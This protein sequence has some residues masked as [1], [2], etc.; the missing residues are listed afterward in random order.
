MMRKIKNKYLLFFLFFFLF[1]FSKNVFA[2]DEEQ[3]PSENTLYKDYQYVIDSYDVNVVVN[4][5]NTFDITETITV[6]YQVPKHGIYRKIP[7]RN[8]ITRLDG[9]TSKNYAVLTNPAVNE[10]FSFTKE[11]GEY[12]FKIGKNDTTLTGEKTYVIQYQYNIGKDPLKEKDEFYFN[13]IGDSW[14]T[15]IGNVTFLI[16]MP[17]TFDSSKVGFSKGKKGSSDSR[18]IDYTVNQN[19]IIGKY[20]GVLFPEEALTVRLELEEGYFVGAGLPTFPQDYIL[21]LF[22]IF[23]LLVSIFLHHHFGRDQELIETVEFYPPEGL[24]SLEI[25]F[26]Y[27]GYATTKDVTS[28]LIYLASK[29]YLKIQEIDQKALFYKM[30]DY[31][32]TKLKEYEGENLNERLFMNQLFLTTKESEVIEKEEV[33]M[34]DL[35]N[36]F[37]KTLDQILSNINCRE[38]QE[39]IYKKHPKITALI[40]SFIAITFF[41]I[42]YP[43]LLRFG[44]EG[45]FIFALLFPGIGFTVLFNALLGILKRKKTGFSKN[46]N[47]FLLL[48][49]ILFGGI[50]FF[51]MLY[52]LLLYNSCYLM[53]YLLGLLCVFFMLLCVKELPQRTTYGNKMIGKILGFK[54][55]LETAEKE[56][57]EALV[58]ENPS[59]FYD[60]LPYS[61]VLG[62]SKKWIQN[63]EAIS[64]QAPTWYD[65]ADFDH[66]AFESF[67]DSMFSSLESAMTSDPSTDSSTGGG[68]S[69]D[70]SGGGGGSSW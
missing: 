33:T 13:L 54:T 55:F 22:P 60:I 14:D 66:F 61:Y 5:N 6:F 64:I 35:Y 49:S 20:R 31:K 24:N 38:N 27:K 43:P 32:F 67:M 11:T 1:F 34:I 10:D 62:V 39:K 68:S 53:G 58:L 42:T 25:G 56:K 45:T 30:K 70:G 7:M 57:L 17:K 48:W 2:L 12:V 23:F 44:D 65:G 19:Q 52:P 63:F 41:F 3:K 26:L 36:R 29:G 4:E 69:S 15:V 59:Y 47:G 51:A 28:L 46:Q 37:Y 40:Y 9:T 8:K 18:D 16:T 21:F 50:P